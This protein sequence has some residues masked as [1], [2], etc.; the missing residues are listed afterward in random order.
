MQVR[1]NVMAD[2][3]CLFCKIVAGEIQAV[4]VLED[5]TC[6]A[7]MDIGPLADGHV[8]LIPKMHAE[9]L[10]EMPADQAGRMLKHLPALV[11]AVQSATSCQGVNVLQ[12]NGRVAHQEIMHVHFHVIPRNEGDEFSFNWPAGSYAPGLMEELAEGIR[13]KL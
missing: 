5:D 12:N 9:T 3:D 8:L 2:S 6:V 11:K 13:S 10:D 1:R 4:K 7:F